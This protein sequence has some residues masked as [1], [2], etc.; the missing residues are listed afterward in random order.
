[1]ELSEGALSVRS[2]DKKG[3]EQVSLR[4]APELGVALQV[5][6]EDMHAI[7]ALVEIDHQVFV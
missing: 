3:R 2:V 4:H 7:D 1:M 6:H 5:L